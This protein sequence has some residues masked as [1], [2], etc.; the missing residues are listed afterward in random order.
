MN[1]NTDN[2]DALWNNFRGEVAKAR[3]GE[4]EMIYTDG[5]T[6]MGH[7]YGGHIAIHQGD[8]DGASMYVCIGRASVSLNCQPEDL[9]TI[10]AHCL[11][12]AE[13]IEEAKAEA[14]AV[15]LAKAS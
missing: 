6:A 3:T 2:F 7:R 13:E 5:D 12:A 10:A 11:A 4:R 15:P 8:E 1:T 14:A 9:R